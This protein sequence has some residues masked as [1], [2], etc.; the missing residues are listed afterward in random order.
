MVVRP[1]YGM[2]PAPLGD[3][4]RNMLIKRCIFSA[5]TILAVSKAHSQSSSAVLPQ[6]VWH[7]SLRY[8]IISEVSNRYDNTGAYQSV[9]RLN[10]VFDGQ[11]IG[12]FVPEFQQLTNFLEATYPNS[13]YVDQLFVGSL[14]FEANAVAQYTAPVLA[15]GVSRRLSVGV[16]IPIVNLQAEV[17]ATQTGASNVQALRNELSQNGLIELNPQLAQ[18]FND[19][20]NANLVESFHNT[21]RQKGYVVPNAVN[22]TVV[23]DIQ[24]VGVYQYWENK[25]WTLYQQTTLNL[26]T[27]PED[28]PDDFLDI[29]VFHQTWLKLQFHQDYS[30]TRKWT[31][32]SHAGYT[33][34]LPDTSLKRVPENENDMLPD[35]SRKERVSRDLGDS[36]NVGLSSNYWL[37]HYLNLGGGYEYTYKNSDDYSGTRGY[38]YDLL[39]RDTESDAHKISITAQF[40]TL[41]WYFTNQFQVPFILSYG[42]SDV[43]AGTNTDRQLTHEMQLK[44]F[45]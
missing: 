37:T 10:Q 33:W 5:I 13:N 23:G 17:V 12:T 15:Y 26:P 35:A 22:R 34:K 18:G 27:G 44:M 29:P 19:L 4:M 40:S 21:L 20:E 31:L 43:V 11:S 9:G 28:N 42:F 41:N 38:N 8:G 1:I 36:V 7:P 45:F 24:L 39:S 25:K 6:G 16:G 3:A 32:G 14:E 2:K 30:L